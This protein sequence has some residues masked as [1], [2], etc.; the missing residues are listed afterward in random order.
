MKR[1]RE[2]VVTIHER[3]HEVI[4][5]VL[6]TIKPRINKGH[7]YVEVEYF[8]SEHTDE[9]VFVQGY[10]TKYERELLRISEASSEGPDGDL[11]DTGVMVTVRA[12]WIE[13]LSVWH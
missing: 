3:G 2:R 12:D 7:P 8:T 10:L 13:T 5:A 9:T 4:D 11:F 1:T 6:E